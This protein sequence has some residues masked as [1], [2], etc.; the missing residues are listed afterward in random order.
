MENCIVKFILN[1]SHD[2]NEIGCY[3]CSE[4]KIIDKDD[5]FGEYIAEI[6]IPNG[7]ILKDEIEKAGK[8]ASIALAKNERNPSDAC[9]FF[10]IDWKSIEIE[11]EKNK[12]KDVF[13]MSTE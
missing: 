9:P 8:I 4:Y 12:I 5:S 10:S 11:S 13:T 2:T 3:S 7:K 1:S 6:T